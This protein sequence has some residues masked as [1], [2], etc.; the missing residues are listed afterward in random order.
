MSKETCSPTEFK[1]FVNKWAKENSE[2]SVYVQ[3]EY[4]EE[5]EVLY[6]PV[7]YCHVLDDGSL[8]INA[9]PKYEDANKTYKLA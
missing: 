8:V 3:L 9:F 6:M 5:G 1:N 2:G 4:G 7:A